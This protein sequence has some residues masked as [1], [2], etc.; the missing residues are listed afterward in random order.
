V[1]RERHADGREEPLALDLAFDNRSP[2]DLSVILGFLNVLTC[3]VFRPTGLT[4]A[5]FGPEEGGDGCL[6]T[7]LEAAVW[8][9]L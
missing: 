1:H 7:L 9:S 8:F 4:A 5:V 2:L 6:A 3:P